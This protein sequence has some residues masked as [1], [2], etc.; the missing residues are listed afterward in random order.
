MKRIIDGKRYDTANAG[1]VAADGFGYSSDFNHWQERLYRTP[2]GSWFLVGSG[3]ARSKYAEQVEQNTWSGGSKLIPMAAEEAR[4][5]CEEHEATE[6]L[7]KH[8]TAE[9]VDA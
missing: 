7:E 1:E 8:F 9:I 5:W 2:G 3:G 4:R 6:A